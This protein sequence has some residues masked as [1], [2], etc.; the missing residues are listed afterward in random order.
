[1]TA[2][3]S[4]IAYPYYWRVKTHLP[5]RKGERCRVIMRGKMNS[6]L[7]EFESDS[8]RVVTSRNYIRKVKQDR[9][10]ILQ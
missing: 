2:Q 8:Y 7:L 4:A 6:C 10:L 5:E 1:M 9:H 3:Q